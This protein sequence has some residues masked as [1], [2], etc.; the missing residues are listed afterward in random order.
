VACNPRDKNQL[1]N[2]LLFQSYPPFDIEWVDCG[3]KAI[4]QIDIGNK[5]VWLDI[6]VKG[7][8]MTAEDITKFLHID[9]LL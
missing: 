4:A 2:H 6:P 3:L 5:D 7:H 8:Q 9:H 1:E